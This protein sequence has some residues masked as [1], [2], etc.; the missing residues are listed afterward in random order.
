MAVSRSSELSIKVLPI[1]EMHGLNG[2]LLSDATFSSALLFSFAS[3][4]K[5]SIVPYTTIYALLS[6]HQSDLNV[7]VLKLIFLLTEY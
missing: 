3:S 2:S 7:D 4:P 6:P 1:F 5:T